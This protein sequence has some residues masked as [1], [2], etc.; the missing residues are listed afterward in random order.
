MTVTKQKVTIT[1]DCD[2]HAAAK[3]KYGNVSGRINELL[4]MDLYGS[5]EKDEL[6]QRLHQLKLEEKSITQRLCELEK[7]EVELQADNS[8][9]DK[10]IQ[11]IEET[12]SRN[13]VIGLN[14]LEAEC[15]R[16]GKLNIEEFIQMMDD[17]GVAYVNFA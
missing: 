16:N 9:R 12:Y 11:W 6:V 1:I 3:S 8:N 2:L 4:A 14:K 10:V 5:D 15:K 17:S 7:R 13:G